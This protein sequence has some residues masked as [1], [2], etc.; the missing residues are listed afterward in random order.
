VMGGAK[1]LQAVGAAA[2]DADPTMQDT[3]SRLLGEWMTTDAGPVLLDLAKT[4]S[5]YEIRAL[6]GYI[7]LARQFNMTDPER[8]AMCRNALR[9]ARRDEEKKLVLEVMERHPSVDMLKFATELAKIPELKN[10]AARISLAIAKKIGGSVDVQRLLTLLGQEPVKVEIIKAEYGTAGKFKD[11]TAM[12]RQHAR[13]LPLIVLPSSSYNTAFGGDPVPG[14]VKQLKVQ[15]RMDGKAGETTFPEDATI[16]LPVPKIAVFRDGR[17][18]R[19]GYRQSPLSTNAA[20]R[21]G[22]A[23]SSTG[24]RS[25][26]RSLTSR[27]PLSRSIQSCAL[28]RASNLL[29]LRSQ[30]FW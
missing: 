16:M 23:W 17:S 10:D 20:Q 18:A 13:D 29:I 11:V 6:R 22:G 28:R 1:A 15:Y 7:R 30:R 19:G 21:R 12:L 9:V 14:V 4:E 3:A 27:R 26:G 2:K 25:F 24:W 8:V 5:K